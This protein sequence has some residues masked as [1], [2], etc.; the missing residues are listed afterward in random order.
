VDSCWIDGE[1]VT[2][3]PGGFY[4]GWITGRVEGPFKGDPMH[5][6]LI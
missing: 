6:E 4:G 5:P 1:R 2:A 3:Q